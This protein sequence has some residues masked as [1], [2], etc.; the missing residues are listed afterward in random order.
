[1]SE[2]NC[3]RAMIGRSPFFGPD[4]GGEKAR[5]KYFLKGFRVQRKAFFGSKID[6]VHNPQGRRA[7]AAEY[8]AVTQFP[9]FLSSIFWQEKGPGALTN[10]AF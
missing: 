9:A 3:K 4:S 2:V 5:Q 1:M 6:R 10:F 8:V 7:R